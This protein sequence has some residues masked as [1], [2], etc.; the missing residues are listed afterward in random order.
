VTDINRT[1]ITFSDGTQNQLLKAQG[2]LLPASEPPGPP[3]LTASGDTCQ[4]GPLRLK[5]LVALQHAEDSSLLSDRLEDLGCSVL[6][7]QDLNEAIGLLQEWQPDLV[8]AE[9]GLG[10]KQPE[11][12]L[13]LADFCLWMEDRVNGWP[14]RRTVVLIPFPDW[15]RFK[16]AQST[17]AHVIVK[18]CDFGAVIRYVETVADGLTTDRILGP[19][20]VGIHRYSGERLAPDCADCEWVCAE[21]SYGTSQ[22]DV[23][24]LTA[25]R[26]ALLN[27]LLFRRRGLHP[28]EIEDICRE[29]P[30]LNKL[31]GKHAFRASAVKMEATRLRKHLDDALRGLGIPYAGRHFLP[32]LSHGT[33]TYCLSGNRR[34]IHVP[35]HLPNL[36]SSP[37]Y[38]SLELRSS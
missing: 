23:Q 33:A 17:G 3:F 36:L 30:F 7:V 28:P 16:R 4:A 12:G 37:R 18:R 20:L 10:P 31:L 1:A 32:L 24:N 9:E 5:V 26:I 22:T 11:G 21:I 2:P 35:V 38:R 25:V 27:T 8:I 13:R 6:L 34:L 15:D 29:S 19:A 14:R